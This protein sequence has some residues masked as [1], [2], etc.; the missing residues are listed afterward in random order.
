MRDER[1]DWESLSIE[2]RDAVEG[3]RKIE[4]I[5][6]LREERGIGLKEAKEAVDRLWDDHAPKRVGGGCGGA[7]LAAFALGLAAADGVQRIVG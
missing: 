3:G 5:K 2:V 4:A 1:I 7:L 6:L